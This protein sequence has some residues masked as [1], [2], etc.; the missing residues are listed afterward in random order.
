MNRFTEYNKEHKTKAQCDF[1]ISIAL[2]N[3]GNKN[4]TILNN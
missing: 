2:L 1:P 4:P 3:N